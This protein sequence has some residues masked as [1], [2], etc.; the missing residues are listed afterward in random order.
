MKNQRKKKREQKGNRSKTGENNAFL[1]ELYPLPYEIMPKE[2][3]LDCL[4][5]G[6]K[7]HNTATY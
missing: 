4:H 2:A 6:I 3:L 7:G 1:T 5:H